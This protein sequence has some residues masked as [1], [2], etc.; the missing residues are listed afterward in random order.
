MNF[1][2]VKSHIYDDWAASV[3]VVVQG[4]VLGA[5]ILIVVR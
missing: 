4:E 1:A 3:F 2:I 5:I